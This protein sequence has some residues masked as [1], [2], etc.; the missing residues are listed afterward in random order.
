[1]STSSMRSPVS[2]STASGRR[3]RWK[4]NILPWTRYDGRPSSETSLVAWGRASAIASRS[5][6]VATA[7]I[8]AVRQS[9]IGTRHRDAEVNDGTDAAAGGDAEGLFSGRERRRS[10]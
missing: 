7:M 5:A 8:F 10:A 1:M 2:G 6:I 3:L 9:L 4:Q